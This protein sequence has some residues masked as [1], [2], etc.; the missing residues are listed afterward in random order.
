[1]IRSSSRLLAAAALALSLPLW[2]GGCVSLLPQAKPA[3]LYRFGTGEGTPAARA[4]GEV[5]GVT[6]SPVSFPREAMGDGIL[7]LDGQQTAY[8]SGAR[9]VAPATILFR[10]TLDR[11]F[12]AAAPRTHLL[13]R[14]EV[15]R[16]SAVLDI[17]VTRFEA[18]YGDPK[19]A[20]VVEVTFLARLAAADGSPVATQ[21]FDV[22]K[23]AAANRITAIVAAYDQAVV[24]ST[25]A[26]ARWTEQNTPDTPRIGVQSST[27]Q[28]TSTKTTTTS[29][30]TPRKR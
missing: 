14:G 1:M 12:D 10:Q 8:I 27:S 29:T 11:S 9:W 7:T 30:T 5:R 17:D 25:T 24:E 2:L 4:A 13:G 19:A 18:R 16:S 15:G 6:L 26:L 22:S 3:Q 28:T 20:P 23:P 21:V